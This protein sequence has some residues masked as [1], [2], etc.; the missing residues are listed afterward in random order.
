MDHSKSISIDH[1]AAERAQPMRAQRR[2]GLRPQG[3]GLRG[4]GGLTNQ[5][6]LVF[7][8]CSLFLQTLIF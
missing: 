7:V 4:A 5:A 2:R 1:T 6:S 3:E 8:R